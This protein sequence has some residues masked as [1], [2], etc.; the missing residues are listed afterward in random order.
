MPDQIQS[1]VNPHKE[2]EELLPWYATGQIEAEEQ[3]L[4]ERHL[5]TCAHCRRQLAFERRMVDEF[6]AMTPEIDSGWARLRERLEPQSQPSGKARESWWDKSVRDAAAAWR[7]LSHP[8]VAAVAFAQLAFVIV[9]GSVLLSLSRPSYRALGSAPPPQ[10]ANVIAMFRP[11][12]SEVQMRELLRTSGASMAGGPTPT[13]AYLLRVPAPS[14][15]RALARLRAD[16]QVLM[17]EPIDGDRS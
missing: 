9:A 17:A 1:G 7:G 4:V 2:A 3:A 10:S 13:D 6:A 12:T 8:A 16:R 15:D 11:D 5:A 14:R